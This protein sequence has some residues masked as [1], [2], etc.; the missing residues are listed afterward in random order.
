MRNPI[1]KRILR[2]LAKEW[3]RYVVLF[4]LMSFM[5]G[6]A[7]GMYVANG[8]MLKAFDESYDK[9]S[10]EDGHLEFKEEPTEELLA[11]MPSNITLYE[12]FYKEVPEVS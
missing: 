3:K 8:S 4:L 9:Y 12:Q 11:K 5:I 7:S 2:D 10:R 1:N 6:T